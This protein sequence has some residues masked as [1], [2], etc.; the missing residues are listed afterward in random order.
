MALTVTITG[1]MNIDQGDEVTLEATVTDSRRK[2]TCRNVTVCMEYLT[3]FFYRY[4]KRGN[5]Y[6]PRRFHG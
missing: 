2:H 4:Y 5:R 3:R 6:L 1:G